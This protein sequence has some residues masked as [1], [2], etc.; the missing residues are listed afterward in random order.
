MSCATQEFLSH[1]PPLPWLHMQQLI[2][3]PHCCCMNFCNGFSVYQEKSSKL[4]LSYFLLWSPF[5]PLLWL[6]C[7]LF[8]W[9]R[10]ILGAVELSAGFQSAVWGLLWLHLFF[11]FLF[12]FHFE[13]DSWRLF[14]CLHTSGTVATMEEES[15][16]QFSDMFTVKILD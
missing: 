3:W 9:G 2:N 13:W 14:L 11:V 12:V 6:G 10:R 4:F 8:L 1:G 5:A 7:V 16:A 15:E